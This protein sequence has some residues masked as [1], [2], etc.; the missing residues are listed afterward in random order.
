[1]LNCKKEFALT[2][3]V[4]LVRNHL[5][6]SERCYVTEERA[7]NILMALKVWG[8]ESTLVFF[9]YFQVSKYIFKSCEHYIWRLARTFPKFMLQIGH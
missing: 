4:I 8:N 3:S 6:L 2:W 9:F 1:M 7:Y 5:S